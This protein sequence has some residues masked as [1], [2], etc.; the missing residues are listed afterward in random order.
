MGLIFLREKDG[1][2]PILYMLFI[3]GTITSIQL[4]GT[5]QSVF[6]LHVK[7]FIA[8]FLTCQRCAFLLGNVGLYV[9]IAY[10][11]HRAFILLFRF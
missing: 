7:R 9:G 11:V 3:Y 8:S 10:L 2:P 4:N 6:L 5:C 1:L